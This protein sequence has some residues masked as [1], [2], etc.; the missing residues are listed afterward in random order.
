MRRQ[1]QLLTCAAYGEDVTNIVEDVMRR[2]GIDTISYA[3]SMITLYIGDMGKSVI[4]F[5]EQHMHPAICA[6]FDIPG[7][8][9]ATIAS[10]VESVLEEYKGLTCVADPP[11]ICLRKTTDWSSG[12]DDVDKDRRLLKNSVFLT[13][14][15]TRI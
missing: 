4:M 2:A 12:R 13:S 15:G 7:S 1:K 11:V 10:I 5:G 8:R 6:D 14:T 3:Y 9:S